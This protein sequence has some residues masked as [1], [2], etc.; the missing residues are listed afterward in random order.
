MDFLDAA[1]E[2][3]TTQHTAATKHTGVERH[4]KPVDNSTLLERMKTAFLDKCAARSAELQRDAEQQDAVMSVL[5]RELVS[6]AEPP[7]DWQAAWEVQNLTLDAESDGE[8]SDRE[9]SEE[10]EEEA[11]AALYRVLDQ[12]KWKL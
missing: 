12:P 7:K 5:S 6:E 9:T 8:E 1:L 11:M 3:A 4:A 2:H 10:E